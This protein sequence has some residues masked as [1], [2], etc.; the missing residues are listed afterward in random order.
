MPALTIGKLAKQTE[1]SR[2]LDADQVGAFCLAHQSSHINWSF[3][4][5]HMLV[6]R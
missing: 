5:T 4:E 3:S 6:Q 1:V 2:L